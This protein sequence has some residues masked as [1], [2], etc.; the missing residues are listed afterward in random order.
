[1]IELTASILSTLILSVT[2][3]VLAVRIRKRNIP[4][5]VIIPLSMIVI[6][7]MLVSFSNILE[8]SDISDFFDP[9]E[10]INEILFTLIFLFFINN[11]NNYTVL[12]D[13]K[14]K[15]TWLRVTVNSIADGVITTDNEGRITHLNYAMEKLTGFNLNESIG[16]NVQDMIRYV[17]RITKKDV[18]YHPVRDIINGKVSVS[19]QGKYLL[20]S[21]GGQTIPVSDNTTVIKGEDSSIIGTVG[22][23]RD[24]SEYESMSAQ[25]NHIHK[26]EAIGQLAGGVAHDLNNMLG[27]VIGAADVLMEGGSL[28]DDQREI[29]DLI[30]KSSSRAADLTKNLLAFSRKGKILSTPVVIQDIINTTISIAEH[31][32]DRQIVIEREISPEPLEVIGDPGQ[33]QNAFLNLL[34]NARDSISGSGKIRVTMRKVYLDAGFCY[35]NKLSLTP[36]DYVSIATMDSG[37]GIPEEIQ[38]RIFEPFFTTKHDG[39][40]TG[41]GLSAVYGTVLSHHGA[42]TLKSSNG[43]GSVFT[44]YLPLYSGPKNYGIYNFADAVEF[45]FSEPGK[46]LVIEDDDILR[47]TA[48]L[49]I[50]DIGFAVVSASNGIEGLELLRRQ[51]DEIKMVL[52]DMVM[53][54]MSGLTVF[55]K[56]KEIDPSAKIIMT[57]GFSQ[58]GQVPKDADGFLPKP[59]RKNQ[60][61][62]IIKKV[63]NTK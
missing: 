30:L 58:E 45:A 26:M 32:I 22:I 43:N 15:E 39:K 63:L 23:Y 9:L 5:N 57:S 7:Y 62:D 12:L 19:A 56:I 27:G 61:T 20:K 25:L 48:R 16:R 34:I 21:K 10:D 28:N 54:E 37:S 47:T 24:M 50:Q 46:I 44:I 49:M 60:L 38:D 31:T 8:H 41:L 1:M 52:L 3:V 53:P 11:W 40:G 59:Y 51:K 42:I 17:D 6:F 13:L 14:E 55:E 33:L 4:L 35:E 29:I 18:D 2:I 36:G